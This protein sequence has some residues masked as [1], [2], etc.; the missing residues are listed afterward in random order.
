M[1][2][3]RR[4]ETAELALGALITFI[5]I[6]ITS[7]I[8]ASLL[9]GIVQ[10]T[11]I[12]SHE[13]AATQSETL[14]GIIQVNRFE[15]SEYS[16]GGKDSVYLVFEFPY[17]LND[18]LDTDVVWSMLCQGATSISYISGDFDTATEIT[19][20]G[21]SAGLNDVFTNAGMYHMFIEIP[22][23]V[24][25]DIS[26]N[27]SAELVIAINGGRTTTI[28]FEVGSNPYAGMIFI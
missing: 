14:N 7:A 24:D 21:V 11:F 3:L 18:V 25:C 9:I 13:H 5:A 20:D 10:T 16:A 15:L 4:S 28:P 8:M 22:G 19:D 27:H 1:E 23:T 2:G 12:N 6:M 26:P 17:L